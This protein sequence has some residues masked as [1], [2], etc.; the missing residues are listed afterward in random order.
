MERTRPCLGK[1][2]ANG[3]WLMV[4]KKVPVSAIE[5]LRSSGETSVKLSKES[6]SCYMGPSGS[7][8]FRTTVS[9]TYSGEN[10]SSFSE[11]RAK[12]SCESDRSFPGQPCVAIGEGG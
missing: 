9:D 2:G 11:V 3:A 5:V 7:E 10:A 6:V 4:T 1:G 12:A 8:G